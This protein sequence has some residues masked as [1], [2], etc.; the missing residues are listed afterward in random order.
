MTQF[1]GAN[2]NNKNQ[3]SGSKKGEKKKEGP[4]N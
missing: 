3:K 1:H 4:G 2:K